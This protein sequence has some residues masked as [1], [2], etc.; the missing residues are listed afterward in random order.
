MSFS[1]LARYVKLEKLGEGNYGCV[2]KARDEWDGGRVVALKKIKFVGEDNGVPCTAV[3]E[4]SVLQALRH[5]AVVPLLDVI[6]SLDHLYLAFPFYDKDVRRY[7]DCVGDLHPMAVK[8]SAA[9]APLQASHPPDRCARG[10]AH[11]LH[12]SLCVSACCCCARLR[13]M[14]QLLRGLQHCHSHRVLHR[15]LKPQNLLINRRGELQLADFGLARTIAWPH[16]DTMTHDVATLWYRAP[17]IL[18]GQKVYTEAMDLWAV[19]CIF[20]ELSNDAPLFAGDSEIA[21]LFKI[22]QSPTPTHA[23]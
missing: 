10:F 11:R 5:E 13:Y 1:S 20:A 17:E 3:R 15:D 12:L 6:F 7:M 22:F 8:W 4:I 14:L 9:A 2:Y 18:L 19:G 23:H 21:T 16:S